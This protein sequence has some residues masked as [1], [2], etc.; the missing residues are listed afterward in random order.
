MSLKSTQ[1]CRMALYAVLL[2]FP[3]PEIKRPKPAP[4]GQ[5][6]VPVHKTEKWKNSSIQG[7]TVA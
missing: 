5:C 6:T 3:F 4:A 2:Q 7:G 1:L